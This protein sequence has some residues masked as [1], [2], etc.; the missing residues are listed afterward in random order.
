[1]ASKPTTATTIE[2]LVATL[3]REHDIRASWELYR[4]R[5]RY[6]ITGEGGVPMGARLERMLWGVWR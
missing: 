4:L 3:N 2:E 5:W 1:M 6:I